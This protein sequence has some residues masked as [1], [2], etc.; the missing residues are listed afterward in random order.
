MAVGANARE[1]VRLY[2]RA[3][4]GDAF[5]VAFFGLEFVLATAL[6]RPGDPLDTE[7]EVASCAGAPRVTVLAYPPLPSSRRAGRRHFLCRRRR[8]C[9]GRVPDPLQQVIHEPCD[10]HI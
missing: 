5:A 3:I 2:S 1:L 9:R 8:R 10:V 6:A 4:G 7:L